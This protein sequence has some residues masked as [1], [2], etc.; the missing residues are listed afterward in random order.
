MDCKKSD[1]A[2]KDFSSEIFIAISDHISF[3]IKR[4]N[5]GIYLPNIILNETKMLY[6]EEYEVGLLALDHIKK[7]Q[8]CS[9]MKMKRDTLLCIWQIFH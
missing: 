4:K 7:K 3:A 2:E 8:V 6:K 5:E 1:T 9:W